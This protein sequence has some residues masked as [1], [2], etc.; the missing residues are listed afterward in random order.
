MLYWCCW[1]WY[2]YWWYCVV[3]E[4]DVFVNHSSFELIWV[5]PWVRKG[6]SVLKMLVGA[7][8]GWLFTAKSADVGVI[9]IH[10][11]VLMVFQ[12]LSEMSF[13]AQLW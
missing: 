12:I 3:E 11:C 10:Q 9:C 1:D 6:G 5:K 8:Y 7:D 13:L 2:W 4:Y